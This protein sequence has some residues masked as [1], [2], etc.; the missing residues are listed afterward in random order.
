[1]R[2]DKLEQLIKEQ[3]NLQMMLLERLLLKTEKVENYLKNKDGFN[4]SHHGVILDSEFLENFPMNNQFTF[5]TIENLILNNTNFT[6]KL[7]Q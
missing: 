5:S 6:E 4:S 2:L 7:V 1:M 3:H